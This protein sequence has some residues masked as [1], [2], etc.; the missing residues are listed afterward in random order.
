M[1]QEK[2]FKT[3]DKRNKGW[4]WLNNEYLNGYGKRLGAVGVSIYVDLCRHADNDQKCFPSEKTIA[5]ELKITDR[6]VRKYIKLFEKYHLIEITKERSIKGKWL[7]NVYWL[8]DKTEWLEPEETISDGKPEETKDIS[9]GNETHIHRKLFPLNNT[10]KKNTNKN[11]SF[12]IEYPTLKQ[13]KE[14]AKIK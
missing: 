14:R 8:T 9:R 11:N 5:K 12:S 1:K 13:I 2:L 3:R 10:N 6:T 7:N 4:F